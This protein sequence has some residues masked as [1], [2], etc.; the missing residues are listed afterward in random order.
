M[1]A[2]FLG[3]SNPINFIV[4]LLLFFAAFFLHF[5]LDFFSARPI[6]NSSVEI[7]GIL[8][9]FT[10]LFFFVNFIVAKNHLTFDNSYALLFYLLFISFFT[11]Y[12]IDY[13]TLFVCLVQLF[14]LRKIYSLQTLNEIFKKLFDAGFW[15]GV[16][17]II[18]PFLSVFF[19]LIFAALLA[20][21][22]VRFQTLLIPVIGFCI[23]VFLFFTYHFWFDQ[24]DRFTSHFLL[25]TSY[26]FSLYSENRFYA[27]L[28]L[29]F[30]GIFS[31][32][33]M[34][35][36]KA[37]YLNKTLKKSWIL[38]LIHLLV[39]STYILF[40]FERNGSELLMAAFPVALILAN[41][42]EL[43]QKRWLQESI[44]LF[45]ILAAFSLPLVL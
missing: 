17:A 32:I 41:G 19:V 3:K 28:G 15:L 31:A 29:L 11:S 1:L 23:P 39:S 35:L 16:L 44:L 12:F 43:I 20:G 26:D 10:V 9:F 8:V 14:F 27:P 42:F 4:L 25:Y 2:N 36:G 7:V 5:L 40:V 33:F 21:K 24:T 22:M 18:D 45:L 13:Q 6:L 30:V 38:L 34:K 37:L